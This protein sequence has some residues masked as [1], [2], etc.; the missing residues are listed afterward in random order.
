MV[1]HSLPPPVFDASHPRL[2][3]EVA[4]R[5]IRVVKKTSPA[6]KFKAFDMQCLGSEREKLRQRIWV[7]KRRKLEGKDCLNKGGHGAR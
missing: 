2:W 1:G 4:L 3:F 5:S 7:R 6:D